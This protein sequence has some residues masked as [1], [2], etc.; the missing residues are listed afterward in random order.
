MN[1]AGTLGSLGLRRWSGRNVTWLGALLIGAIV[2]LAAYDIVRSYSF[3]VAENGRLLQTGVQ[4]IAEQTARSMQAVDVALRNLAEQYERG[5]LKNLGPREL[6][7]LLRD[8]AADL[9]QTDGIALHDAN[10][11]A[12]GLSWMF[13]ISQGSANV[14][15]QAQF[16][17]VRDHVTSDL[18]VGDALQSYADRQWFFPISRRLQTP[19]GEF[20]GMLSAR[21]SIEYYQQFYHDIQPEPSTKVTLMHRDG[22]LLARF[23]PVEAAYGKRYPLLDEMLAARDA[24]QPPPLRQISPVDGVD[25]FG[26]VRAVPNYPLVVVLTR[27]VAAALAPWRAQAIGTAL[28]TLALAGL[29]VALL[30]I[31]KR[32]LSNLDGARQSLERSQE[33]FALAVAG[34]DDGIWDWDYQAGVAFGSRRAREILGLPPGP[35]SQPIDDWFAALEQQFHPDDRPLRIAAIEAHLTGKRP[36][37]EGEYRVRKPDGGYR[38]VRIRGLSVRRGTERPHRMAGSV[39]D[40]D[41]RKCAEECLRLSEERYALA[42]TGSRGGHWV[43]DVASDAL[44]VSGTVNQLFGLPENTQATTRTAYFAQIAP[45]PDDRLRLQQVEADLLSGKS[46]RADFEYRIL[47]GAARDVRWILMRAQCFRDAAGNAVQVAGVSVDIS[48]RKC[49]EEALRLSEERYALAMTG[50]NE[51]HWVWELQKDELF[52]S[53]TMNEIFGLPADEKITRWSDYFDRVPIPPEDFV[54]VQAA[55]RAQF[56]GTS[57]RLDIDHRIIM[58]D[59]SVRWVHSRGQCF[60]DAEGKA[61]R[62]AGATI[63]ISDRKHAEEALRKSEER[64][65]LAMTGSNEGH[66]DWNI[67]TDELFAS[68]R[69]NEMLGLPARPVITTHTEH[70]RILP[71]HPDDAP[72]VIKARND[73]LAG[74]IPR[75]DLEYRIVLPATGEVRWIHTRAQCFRDADGKPVRMAGALTDITDRKRTE[76][77]LRTSEERFAVSVAGSNDGIVDWDILNDRMYASERAMQIL[78]L[79]TTVTVRS[80]AEWRALIAYHP[81]DTQRV[82]D[83]LRRCLEGDADMRDG[84]YRVRLR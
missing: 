9:V 31:L 17:S 77:A 45:H 49:T 5:D 75:F 10:G 81:D 27:D 52:V 22:T 82:R 67:T 6:N 63:D 15:N 78:D 2:A 34:S 1:F 33:R 13:P 57:E 11:N 50:S 79:G 16:R 39:S 32:Q 29:A 70:E 30:A 84:E 46:S 55:F 73:H 14:S 54:E 35:E 47:L 43:W 59:G 83:D 62:M 58:Q 40:I 69:L 42:M 64:Y 71:R 44:F 51:G 80:R 37:Y 74:L 19:S 76:E 24:G 53:P 4:I 61:V 41:A 65:A 60:R 8:K 18:V 38:W 7:I 21:G 25:R 28:R 56:G 48:E 3:T 12:L 66:W 68:A 26:A 20:A 23:P 36:T 72:R